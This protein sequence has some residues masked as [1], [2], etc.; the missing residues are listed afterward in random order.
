MRVVPIGVSGE[1]F[2]GGL[3]LARGYL[4][5]PDLTAERFLPHPFGRQPGT[6]L[7]R[8]GDL[9]RYRE[10]GVLECLGRVDQ[11]VKIRGTRI[12]R[13]G[14]EPGLGRHRSVEETAAMAWTNPATA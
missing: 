5:R 13:G 10:D 6:R 12:G 11:Q 9:A 3:G 8:T 4:N 14:I 2:I 1:L 7:Y